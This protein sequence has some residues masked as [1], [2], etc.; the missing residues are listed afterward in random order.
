MVIGLDGATWQLAR[1]WAEVGHLPTFQ[2]LMAEGAWGALGS[3]LPPVTPAAWSS[4]A[5]GMNPGKHG[6][7]DFVGRQDGS[8]GTYVAN[9]SY[10]D[11]APLW[12]LASQA[13]RRVTVFNVPA[14]YPPDKVNGLMVS[15]FLTPAHAADATWPP[16]LQ[17]ELAQA[18][19]QFTFYPP[20][21]YSPGHE[22]DFVQAVSDL[23]QATLEAVRYLL[24][25]EPWDLFVAVF[26]GTDVI[27]HFLWGYMAQGNEGLGSAIL[28]CHRQMD[29]TL[30][31]LLAG[32]GPDDYLVVMSDHGF[33]PLTHYIHVNAWLVE[34]GYLKFKR[35]PLSA[36]KAVA[37]RLGFTPLGMY[38]RLRALGLGGRMQETASERN[39]W[40]KA[41][42]QKV[43]LSLPDVDWGRT[44]AYS[45]GFGG[46]IFVNLRG[47]EPQGIVAP[48]AEY[49]ALRAQIATDLARTTDPET[50]Q[51]FVGH[52]YRREQL[53]TGP[54]AGRA[55]DLI[56]VPRNWSHQPFGTHEFASHRWLEPCRDR[57]GTHRLDGLLLLWGPGVRRGTQV[58]GATIVDVAPTVLALLGVPIPADMDGRVL[59]A[60]LEGGLLADLNITYEEAGERITAHQ[61]APQMSAE[62]EELIRQHLRGL[63]YVA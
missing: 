14:T 8:Y 38:E 9:A 18:V 42:V 30:A 33:G 43:F 27:Q 19:P 35:N 57:S 3:T 22:A 10:R 23:N 61:P 59:S 24:R 51:P 26:M 6:L 13:G 1:P 34:R 52:I 21:I 2:R 17:A 45:L 29:A 55:P 4:F 49:E 5:T 28:D 16:Q 50:G 31:E 12:Q 32:L 54:H 41:R 60:A 46:P 39:E 44:Q 36:L 62:D 25:R 15:G 7:F 40:L 37:Y 63:G 20:N 11:G 58:E 53:Y 56:L 47:R 48:G